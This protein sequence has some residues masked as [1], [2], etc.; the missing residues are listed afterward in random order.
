MMAIPANTTI[1][2]TTAAT[3]HRV[4]RARGPVAWPAWFS[5]TTTARRQRH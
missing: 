1:A 2:T 3:Q 4:R 5:A